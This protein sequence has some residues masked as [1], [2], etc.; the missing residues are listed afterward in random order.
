MK[1]LALLLIVIAAL[2]LQLRAQSLNARFSTSLYSYERN[3]GENTSVN[4]LR[5]YQTAQFTVG[6]LANNRLSFHFFGQISQDLSESADDDPIPRLYN[7][8]LQWEERPPAGRA[9]SAILNRVKLGRQRLYSG[10]AYGAIDGIDLTL[11]AGNLFKV[12]G[13]AGFLVPTS[14][15]I[16]IDSWDASHAFGLRASSDRLLGS[17]ILISFMQR[18]RQP[19]NYTAPGQFTQRIL[20]F[21]SLEQRLV[22]VDFYRSF[23]RQLNFY[24][25]FDYDLEQERVRRTQVE[26]RVSPTQK[27]E[28]AGEFFHRAPLIDA[29][30]I[31]TVFEQNTSQDVGL[32]ANYRL[33]QTWFIDGNFGY[34]IYDGD[35]SIR[36]GLGL[37]CKYGYFGYNFRRGYGGKNNGAY[38]ALNYQLN[39]KFG[40]VASSGLSRYSLFNEDTDEYT[41]ITGSVGVNYRPHKLF[42]VDVLGQAVRNRFFSNDF[43][44]FAKANYW[45]FTA[46]K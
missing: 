4:Y 32:R 3:L 11:R 42:S 24:G 44:F 2:P 15:E 10:V 34:Q 31:F 6:Q 37:R 17:K 43:R 29:N 14:N 22:G 7:A 12:G 35:E 23:S 5:L 36:F 41:S 28:L 19:V 45:F 8:Y 33:N 46:K 21:E 9:G 40:V 39:S 27:L 18:N 38:A 30:S 25:R 1:K 13:F 26:L 16:E 20:T